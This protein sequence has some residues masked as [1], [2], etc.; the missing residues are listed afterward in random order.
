MAHSK[1]RRIA[2]GPDGSFRVVG[3]H[4][5]GSPQDDFSV[6]VQPLRFLT[7]AKRNAEAIFRD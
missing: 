3:K 7:G 4:A 2:F 1:G 5:N 6:F